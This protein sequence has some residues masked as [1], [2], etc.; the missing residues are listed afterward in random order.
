MK[1]ALFMTV[2]TGTKTNNN[3]NHGR[4][5]QIQGIIFTIS[6]MNPE[7]VLFFVSKESEQTI[8][9]VKEKYYKK[10]NNEFDK[11]YNSDIVSL[12]DVY[13][14]DSCYFEI[15]KEFPKYNDFDI[16]VSFIGGTKIMTSCICIWAGI[17]NKKIVI[18]KGEPDE[19]RK[20]RNTELEIKEP[21]EIQDKIN[22]D[23]FKD[24]FDNH[25]FDFAKEKLKDIN[26][27]VNKE[28]F[29]ELLDF[30][31]TWDK[32][33]DRIEISN[34]SESNK[35]TLSLNTHLRNIIS[36]LKENDNY[37]EILKNYPN[38]FNQIEKNQQFL[39]NKISKNNRKIATKIKFYLPDLLNNIERRI[40]ER[41]FDDAVARLYRAVELISQIK[42]NNLDLIDLNRLKD[43]KVFHINKE[44]FKKKLYE[45]YD[46]GVVDCI[47]D[48][49][50][51]KD[52]KS[53]PQDKTFR[54]AMNSNFFLLDDLKVNFAKKFINDE[55]FKAEVQKRNNSILAHGLN[56]IDEKTANN[57][58]ESVLEYSFH[59][60]PKIKDDMIL[61]KFPDFGGN[62]EN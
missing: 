4:E 3:N 17:F 11:K 45:Y 38:F 35:K 10:Y 24:A 30:Y 36:K 20:I 52:F 16:N 48:F 26:T 28:F 32:F 2:G 31:D 50:V 37:D 51:K 44:S 9:L 23:K 19:N 29:M 60:Y 41:K 5:S 7:F 22:F 12:S 61:A 56:P 53:K 33:N 13:D 54:L 62:N 1:K 8:D 49:H 14:F 58:F 43:N 21:Y 6:K 46:D 39:D 47:F 25:R 55:K 15:E 18:A 34:N 40:K 42:L 59:L 27:L 57:L